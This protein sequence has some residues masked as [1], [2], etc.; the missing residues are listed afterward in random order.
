MA[1][2]CITSE[3]VA[4]APPSA[5]ASAAP[6]TPSAAPPTQAPTDA[7]TPAPTATPTEVPTATPTDAPTDSPTDAPSDAPTDAPT[8]EP[9]A[10]PDPWRQTAQ[11]YRGNDAQRYTIDCSP[12]GTAATI[13]GTTFYTDDSSIC[14]AAVHRGDIT[15]ASGGTVTYEMAPGQDSYEGSEQNGITSRDYPSWPGSF[16]IVIE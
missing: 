12:S 6:A 10:T 8:D 15:L 9:A 14:T 1:A 7:P 5:S 13:W 11:Q 3:P 4:T 16:V 2:A